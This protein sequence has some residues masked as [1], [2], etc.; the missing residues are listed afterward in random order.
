MATHILT[1]T[2]RNRTDFTTED[3]SAPIAPR[4]SEPFSYTKVLEYLDRC[5]SKQTGEVMDSINKRLVKHTEEVTNQIIAFEVKILQQLSKLRTKLDDV[6]GRV[7]LME[8][9]INVLEEKMETQSLWPTNFV[10]LAFRLYRMK[11]CWMFSII[12]AI[13]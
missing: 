12:S 3:S 11:I 10:S 8:Q 13:S 7:V 6:E 1:R 2:K 4:N 5:H 9:R